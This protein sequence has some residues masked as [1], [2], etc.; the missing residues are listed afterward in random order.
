M[1]VTHNPVR[2]R[3]EM[4][5]EHGLAIAEYRQQ[6]DRL[7]FTHAEVP[8]KDQGKGLAAKLVDAALKDT[9]RRD[10]KIVPACSYIVAYVRR[11]PEFDDSAR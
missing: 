8:P 6:G 7:V 1:S 4:P 11:H 9:H 3:Y 10:L 2:S 5:T